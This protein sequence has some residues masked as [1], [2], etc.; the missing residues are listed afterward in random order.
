MAEPIN[1]V[2]TGDRNNYLARLKQWLQLQVLQ[3]NLSNAESDDTYT[4]TE[5][6]LHATSTGGGWGRRPFYLNDYESVVNLDPLAENPLN[7][8]QLPSYTKVMSVPTTEWRANIRATTDTALGRIAT[9]QSNLAN[10]IP[11]LNEYLQYST[12][13]GQITEAERQQIISS[14]TR[15]LQSGV[16]PQELPNYS[17]VQGFMSYQEQQP[18]RQQQIALRD[19]TSARAVENAQQSQEQYSPWGN[20]PVGW[21][22]GRVS[23]ENQQRWMQQDPTDLSAMTTVSPQNMETYLR[24]QEPRWEAVRNQQLAQLTEP[25]N[26]VQKKERELMPNPYTQELEAAGW[27]RGYQTATTE[28]ETPAWLAGMAGLKA[29][30]P[31]T[32]NVNLRTPSAQQWQSYTPTQ[33]EMYAGYTNWAGGRSYAD[34]TAEMTKMLP[35]TPRGAGVS[36][37]RPVTQRTGRG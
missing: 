18:Q 36:T 9:R 12:S 37:W 11:Q 20:N 1:S 15:Q 31:L 26:W 3:G 34:I 7:V 6:L 10:Y 22:M 13:K 19:W 23:Q 24:I 28:I 25:Y 8:P 27:G 2:N 33:Q 32:K 5:Q 14:E 30:T 17:G 35:Y 16:S 4:Q 21:G 29:G